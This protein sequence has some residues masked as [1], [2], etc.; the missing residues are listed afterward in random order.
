M[1]MRSASAASA[2]GAQAPEGRPGEY[3]E[4]VGV[5]TGRWLFLGLDG[6]LTAYLPVA[7]GV[8]RWTQDRPGATRWTGPEFFAAPHVRFM[9]LT[10][11]ADGYV[12]L[13][14]RRARRRADG[15]VTVDI[16]H[17][18]QYQTGRPLSE[19]RGLGN[20]YKDPEAARKFGRPS[21]VADASGTV[22]V[23]VRNGAGG[24]HL[25]REGVG[26][27]WQPWE[28]LGGEQA[29]HGLAPA[30]TASGRIELLAP[31][32]G[33]ALHWYQAEAGGQLLRGQDIPQVPVAGSAV[34]LETARERVSFY[35]S[36]PVGGIVAQRPGNWPVAL[37]S[38]TDDT[39]LAAVRTFI[40]GY[41]CTVL[42]HRGATGAIMLSAFV[43]ESE[44]NGVWWSDTGRRCVGGPGLAVDAYGRV[45]LA[46]VDESGAL[47][48]SHQTE[49]QGLALG[50]WYRI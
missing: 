24:V 32:R 1:P 40:D 34:G 48:I 45:T 31:A 15:T 3:L 37:G 41:D 25:R 36:D 42:A 28:D 18:I 10:Q 11:G 43:N 5:E 30:V 50:D 12:H 8:Q 47:W 17:A 49:G 23:F 13:L 35:W 27:K 38:A 33:S 22:H 26:G 39:Q 20:P 2:R 29:V 7:G 14:G 16:V 46:A 4:P 6:R 44:A 19:W 21:G 9:S